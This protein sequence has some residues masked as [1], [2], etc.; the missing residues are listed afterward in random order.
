MKELDLTFSRFA[1]ERYE[2]AK[3][4]ERARNYSTLKRKQR[5]SKVMEI[6]NNV[7]TTLLL[8][9][10]FIGIPMLMFLHWLAFGY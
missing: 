6:K 5:E 10:T 4:N 3:R 8:C 7:M 9:A 1:N 2:I